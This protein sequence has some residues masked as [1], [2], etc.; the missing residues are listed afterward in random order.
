MFIN[1]SIRNPEGVGGV[2][3]TEQE[4]LFPLDGEPIHSNEVHFSEK[5]VPYLGIRVQLLEIHFLRQ[6]FE[7]NSQFLCD[8]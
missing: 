2:I 1:S 5:F 8:P 3:L 6:V 4:H 7:A